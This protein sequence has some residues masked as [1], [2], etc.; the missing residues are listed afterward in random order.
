M[1]TGPDD[2]DVEL[3]GLRARLAEAEEILQAIR[4]GEVDAVIVN[5]E[6]APAVYTLKSA[7]SPYRLLVEQMREGAATLSDQGI[8]LYCNAAFARMVGA[9]GDRLRGSSIADLIANPAGGNLALVP[10]PGGTW[11]RDLMLRTSSGEVR[12][13]YIS[14]SPLASDGERIHCVVVTDLTRLGLRLRHDAIVNSSADAIYSLTP[15]G[16]I[17]TWNRAAEDLYGYS[18]QEALGRNVEILIPAKL[19]DHPPERSPALF[20]QE[21]IAQ[22]ETVR[23]SKA[24]EPIHVALSVAPIE[25]AGGEV[26]GVSVI[27]RDITE[28]KRAQDR[29]HFLLRETSHRS[30]NLLA[31]I[32]A[33]ASQTARSGGTVE[34]FE[35]RLI[36][37]L[38]GI[39]VS[40]DLIVDENWE[41]VNLADL[42]LRQVKPLFEHEQRLR[43]E[44]P[45]VYLTPEAAQNMGFAL[46][47]LA[48][49]AVKYGALSGLTGNV[50]VVWTL[51]DCGGDRR[52]RLS[53]RESNGPP[54]TPPSHA[55]FGS[56]VLKELVSLSL[57][58]QITSDFAPDGFRWE[59]NAPLAKVIA[60]NRARAAERYYRHMLVVGTSAIIEALA[61]S[62]A[63]ASSGWP[64]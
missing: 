57:D 59:L 63:G 16:I 55:G 45:P 60:M 27:A 22:H 48:T 8:I 18:A 46:H 11:G 12:H 58:A 14:S 61:P 50:D 20:V 64:H 29:L 40:H 5:R 9:S 32:Q 6:D 7:D 1:S 23:V 56:T 26:E 31:V 13:V 44:G 49:N 38:H 24:G 52:L 21:K 3:R 4:A 37:R 47:E 28:R 39:A 41:R 35:T 15:E 54:V 62:C 25:G 2:R 19:E 53:W 36:Q 51:E 42:V 43:I 34:E 17:T 33:M 30:K 10:P